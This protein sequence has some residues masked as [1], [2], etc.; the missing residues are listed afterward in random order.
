MKKRCIILIGLFAL[1]LGIVTPAFA[2]FSA[3]E[4]DRSDIVDVSGTNAVFETVNNDYYKVIFF[5]SPYY[6]TGA[7]IGTETLDDPLA[8]ANHANNPYD[9]A[10]E[11]MLV[12]PRLS[13][14]QEIYSNAKFQSGDLHYIS[15]KKKNVDVLTGEY[16][17]LELFSKR[18]YTGYI[19][20][21]ESFGIKENTSK[22]VSLTVKSSISADQFNAIVAA[23]EFRDR[24][25]FGPEFIGWTYDKAATAKRATYTV[26]EG[27][28]GARTIRYKVE[29]GFAVGD[30]R[31][32]GVSGTSGALPYGYGDYG[33]QGEA[34]QISANTP[35]NYIDELGVDGSKKGDKVIYLYPVFAAKNY[36]GEKSQQI[37]NNY[38]ALMKFRVNPDQSEVNGIKRYVYQQSAEID[39]SKNRYTVGL[40]QR[41]LNSAKNNVNYYVRNLLINNEDELQ[42]DINPVSGRNAWGAAWTTLLSNDDIRALNLE[43]GNYNIDITYVPIG[44]TELVGAE[45]VQALY[46]RYRATNKYVTVCSSQG[47]KRL[48]LEYGGTSYVSVYY[49]I[50][51]QRIHEFHLTGNSLNGAIGDYASEG[52]KPL[53]IVSNTDDFHLYMTTTVHLNAGDELAVLMEDTTLNSL[54]YRLT[55]MS[56]SFIASDITPSFGDGYTVVGSTATSTEPIQLAEG[57]KK[58]QVKEGGSYNFFYRI[59]YVEGE[60]SSI[61]VCARKNQTEYAF[62][63]LKLPPEQEFFYDYGALLTDE[64]FY[65]ACTKELNSVMTSDMVLYYSFAQDEESGNWVVQEGSLSETIGEVLQEYKL[66]DSATGLELKADL[67]TS[68][69]FTLNRNY[70]VYL[71]ARLAPIGG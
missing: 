32:Y 49:V 30:S 67:F 66:I 48:Y 3:G 6:A 63:I 52:Y 14:S 24:Y 50:G 41:N 29:E 55:S 12:G 35:L 9:D 16:G 60:P 56:S 57:G 10:S 25:G 58:L 4:D 42:L 69:E 18:D 2:H 64:Q 45:T 19:R 70:I 5:A 1:L 33:C 31:G 7:E 13:A 44:G 54:P 20:S 36:D 40:S 71:Q 68:G 22:Y 15:Y 21:N 23:T 65:C 61:E 46:D 28:S 39:Y 17:Q 26:Y 27:T 53:H 38:T 43:A 8:I 47:V 59:D 62:V 11:Y 34:E 37:D 51:F